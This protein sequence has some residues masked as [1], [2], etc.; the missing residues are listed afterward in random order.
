[1]LNGIKNQQQTIAQHSTT[2]QCG[3][4]KEVVLSIQWD[5]LTGDRR[6]PTL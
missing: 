5:Q 2:T 4:R 3:L 6:T 1:M